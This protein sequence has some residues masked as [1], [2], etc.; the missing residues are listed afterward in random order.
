MT[1]EGQR[2]RWLTAVD[3][4]DDEEDGE[5]AVVVVVV[6]D[7]AVVV[8]VVVGGSAPVDATQEH[9]TATHNDIAIPDKSGCQKV[10]SPLPY[11]AFSHNIYCNSCDS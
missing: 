2:Y 3:V 11:T 8:V 9:H 10:I 1:A 4:A 5:D 7:N 6:V